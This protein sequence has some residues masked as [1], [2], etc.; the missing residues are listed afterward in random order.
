MTLQLLQGAL[1][2]L[3]MA[4]R[5]HKQWQKVLAHSNFYLF[6]PKKRE[7][8]GKRRRND[9]D[10]GTHIHRNKVRLDFFTSF[11][12]RMAF[13]FF[14]HF[15]RS[16]HAHKKCNK[17]ARKRVKS[18][19]KCIRDLNKHCKRHWMMMKRKK[20]LKWTWS[21]KI[22]SSCTSQQSL[23]KINKQTIN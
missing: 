16:W 19:Q 1:S 8:N 7:K 3:L 11:H 23:I 18:W 2:W 20:R 5:T 14:L 12:H 10:I 17:K 9:C 4:H 22:F 13:F 15:T 21:R 6:F